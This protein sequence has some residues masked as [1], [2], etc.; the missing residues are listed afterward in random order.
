MKSSFLNRGNPLNQRIAF[1][2]RSNFL[3]S[4]HTEG[5][6]SLAS[7]NESSRFNRISLVISG[8]VAV[9]YSSIGASH[10]SGL[11]GDG[12]AVITGDGQVITS[13]LC[14]GLGHGIGA[15]GQADVPGQSQAVNGSIVLGQ[16]LIAD[17]NL[18]ILRDLIC[19]DTGK[20]LGHGNGGFSF[21]G[22]SCTNGAK[23][24]QHA[25]G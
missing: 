19:L 7:D 6:I 23:A 18:E 20:D 5:V 3:K 2:L 21:F 11:G 17:G 15:K 1:S 25:D 16:N 8:L 22:S 13:N 12:L 14:T 4:P 24:H 9:G 10:L